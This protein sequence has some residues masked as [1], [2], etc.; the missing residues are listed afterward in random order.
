SSAFRIRAVSICRHWP[1][2]SSPT[3]PRS[4]AEIRSGGRCSTT[5]N[6]SSPNGCGRAAACAGCPPSWSESLPIVNQIRGTD[7]ARYLHVRGKKL[8]C[9][10]TMLQAPETWHEEGTAADIFDV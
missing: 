6:Y 3:S 8:S 5:E 7:D 4:R 10:R 1:A 2:A 9:R